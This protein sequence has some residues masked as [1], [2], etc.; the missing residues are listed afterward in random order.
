MVLISGIPEPQAYGANIR[1]NEALN[2]ANSKA[3]KTYPMY[4]MMYGPVPL[5]LRPKISG[6]VFHYKFTRG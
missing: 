1:T 4:E 6:Q 2:E 5:R 3:H